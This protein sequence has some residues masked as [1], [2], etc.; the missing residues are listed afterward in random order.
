MA[1]TFASSC[2][3]T[4][5]NGGNCSSGQVTRELTEVTEGLAEGEQVV[6][7]PTRAEIEGDAVPARGEE[8]AGE[9]PAASAPPSLTGTVAAS[10]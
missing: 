9:T 10:H 7:N 1:T 8:P 3:T 4:A 2:T 6:L 5:W